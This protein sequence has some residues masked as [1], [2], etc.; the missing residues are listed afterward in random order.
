[1]DPAKGQQVLVVLE[2]E[3]F[4]NVLHVTEI[5]TSRLFRDHYMSQHE[6]IVSLR[7]RDHHTDRRERKIFKPF[8]GSW[9]H[10]MVRQEITST[11][12]T[13]IK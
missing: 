1:M 10:Q 11:T 9:N 13:K 2:T 3:Q 6:F 4:L 5:W 12:P 7:A 8:K